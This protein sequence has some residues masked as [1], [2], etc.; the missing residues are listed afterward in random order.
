MWNQSDTCLESQVCAYRQLI[1]KN[2]PC[3]AAESGIP[4]AGSLKLRGCC[5]RLAV[6]AVKL[7]GL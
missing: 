7:F 1:E 2:R 3:F 5:M 4:V 6:A